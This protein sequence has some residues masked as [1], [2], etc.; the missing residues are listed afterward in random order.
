MIKFLQLPLIF[1]T[2]QTL[3]VAEDGLPAVIPEYSGSEEAPEIVEQYNDNLL[4]NGGFTEGTATW[5]LAPMF[6]SAVLTPDEGALRI[7]NE[8][9]SS[10]LVHDGR[11]PL[12]GSIYKLTFRARAGEPV[13][14]ARGK[15]ISPTVGMET[16]VYGNRSRSGP[17]IYM[18]DIPTLRP[19]PVG[20]E[21]NDYSVRFWT[22]PIWYNRNLAVAM[23]TT[24][25]VLLDDVE[26]RRLETK[27][28]QVPDRLMRNRHNSEGLDS[29]HVNRLTTEL[30]TPHLNFARPSA[31]GPVKAFF[32]VAIQAS[33]G[34][35]DVIEMVQRFD[36]DFSN[37]NMHVPTT[38]A[39]KDLN[40]Y[41]AFQDVSLPEKTA[42]FLATLDEDPDVI[43]L[44][45]IPFSTLP[46]NVQQRVLD[47][48]RNGMGLVLISPRNY[49]DD[50]AGDPV[51]GA[52]EQIL[53]GVPL[54]G[55]PEYFPASEKTLE[56]KASSAVNAYAYGDG[57]V[58]V[59]QWTPELLPA[60][61]GGGVA[62]APAGK[63]WTGSELRY[64][65][66]SPHR[67]L[68]WPRWT[69]QYEHRYNY[70]LSLAAKAIDWA[71]KRD[72]RA[73]WSE[74]PADGAEIRR[75]KLPDHDVPIGIDW[76]GPANQAA[77]LTATVRDPLGEEALATSQFLVLAP[78]SNE[79]TIALPR[80]KH[81]LH[82]LDL[83]LSTTD[84]VENWAT[85]S[86][87]VE[88]PE[89][90]VQLTTREEYISRGDTVSGAVT[91]AG[92]LTKPSQLVI[93][94]RDTYGRVY[95]KTVKRVPAGKQK[96]AFS[97]NL[98]RPNSYGTFIEALLLRDGEEISFADRTVYV[99]KPHFDGFLST[100]WCSVWYEG[101]GQ[102]LMR[103]ARKAGFNS[104]YDRADSFGDYENAA[105]ADMI[106][107]IYASRVAI[108]PDER[109]Y[110]KGFWGHGRLDPEFRRYVD[111]IVLNEVKSIMRLEPPYYSLGDENYFGYGFGFSPH[112]LQAYR[113][114][115]EERYGDIARLNEAYGSSHASFEE[116]PRYKQ[117][118]A[119]AEG[120]LPALIDTRL[121]TD[122][123][124]AGYHHDLGRYI[125]ELDPDA[126]VG[127][128]G[129]LPGDIERMVGGTEYWAPYSASEGQNVLKRSLITRDQLT[130][131]WWGGVE[132]GARDTT[133]LW[134]WLMRDFANFNQWFC[135]LHVDGAL[136]NA[137]YS[138]R[139]FFKKLL[140][141][142][143]EIMSGTALLLRDAEPL[144]EEDIVLHYSRESEHAALMIYEPAGR[145]Q[146]EQAV[147]DAL[148]TLGRDFRYVSSTTIAA[149]KL[150]E[151]A[152][153]ILFLPS[154]HTLSQ[155]AAD[156]IEAFV[157][158]GG[159]VVADFL[160]ALDEFGR[161][162]PEG[163][164]D[165]L[166]GATCAGKRST[167]AVTD[168]SISAELDGQT[169]TLNC[170][171]TMVEGALQVTAAEFLA[172]HDEI[173][174]LAVNR[175]GSGKTVLLNF[176]LSRCGGIEAIHFVDAL[177]NSAG[178]R[179]EFVL[180]G[181]ESSRVFA[182]HRGGLTLLGVILPRL[183]P[184]DPNQEA[185]VIWEEPMHVY[186]V[187]AGRYLGHRNEIA[188]TV[189][190]T[191]RREHLFALQQHPLT[192]L[193]LKG[194]ETIDSGESLELELRL[195][196]G[197]RPAS[198]DRVLRIDV[199]DPLGQTVEHYRDFL[200]V[201]GAKANASVPFAFNDPPGAWTITATDVATG[202]RA[203]RVLE[204]Q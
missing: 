48:V 135:A 5:S 65:Y 121:G 188:V 173:P 118:D 55:L 8:A 54:A 40:H 20:P 94:A 10:A 142:I 38:F 68:Q 132:S 97:I 42:E 115:L 17:D 51:P 101:I 175:R 178:S 29:S 1:L 105:L 2:V 107:T 120:H 18:M 108:T 174:L 47:R 185:T 187:R 147:L 19:K 71:A 156:G 35:R 177:L 203:T 16:Y 196:F 12:D 162:L 190:G 159:T 22:E 145:K 144:G 150:E 114:Y 169:L 58:V 165:T 164:L 26:F 89:K 157:R 200:R 103:Q 119:I 195:D 176:D 111:E 138:Y 15:A 199:T 148:A 49:P 112:G 161:R 91:L 126:R 186:D 191:Q 45:S 197:R 182:S 73:Q 74:L 3:C 77:T 189:S 72:L 100:I 171:E 25:E 76:S 129:S 36:I 21:W 160:P 183:D 30:V 46:G 78:G 122:D 79:T 93:R 32:V 98:D 113:Q 39:W 128:E 28:E 151:P 172:V 131:H 61:D 117:A 84:G 104:V 141:D 116:V 4:E 90:I 198:I 11:F 7:R 102:V 50:L 202:V 59:I 27:V 6:G 170:P 139:P 33:G 56:E 23:R 64:D 53:T 137:D 180:N 143:L 87:S 130:A 13:L 184:M 57:R 99:P 9:N 136:F 31:A 109:G 179:P 193:T 85:V 67:P 34:T 194:P 60:G 125:R 158:N 62:P 124:Y 110:A 166:F 123:D 52:R 106:P 168:L 66:T 37:F 204:L 69:R 153:K 82:Y 192:A 146:A 133:V 75:D 86:F 95:N 134:E 181:S 24:G 155:E 201:Q 88:G 43:V 14:D 44:G 163:R 92:R 70:H 81:G 140:P 63:P 96:A 83:Q 127:A 167:V 152:G 41:G 149:G 154:T 80:L